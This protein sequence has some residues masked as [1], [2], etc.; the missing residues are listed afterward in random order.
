MIIYFIITLA[1][2]SRFVPHVPNFAPITAIA[3][4]S[5]AHLS[6]KKS[7]AIT[8]AARFFSDIF[9]GFFAW[10]LMV[11]VYASHLFG[12]ILGLWIKRN[13]TV[14]PKATKRSEGLSGIYNFGSRIKSGMTEK[15][16]IKIILSPLITSVV[17]FLATNFAFLYA[18]Y[19]HNISGIIQS[20]ANGLPFFRGTLFGD[21]TYTLALFGGYAL[22]MKIQTSLLRQGF[23]GQVKS[24]IQISSV[25]ND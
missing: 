7:F 16:W 10:P 20:Y 1:I 25:G 14:I 22:A 9:L 3:I 11:A 21:L 13:K 5:A 19:P 4:F 15:K 12:V 23:G 6:W 18:N 8:L 17:F 24:K 2:I